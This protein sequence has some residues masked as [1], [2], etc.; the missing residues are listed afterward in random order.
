MSGFSDVGLERAPSDEGMG[1]RVCT[2]GPLDALRVRLW[3][4]A[5]ETTLDVLPLTIS[6]AVEGPESPLPAFFS[7]LSAVTGRRPPA[8]TTPA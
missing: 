6:R 8:G 2:L 3:P 1:L 7:G 5:C 4:E